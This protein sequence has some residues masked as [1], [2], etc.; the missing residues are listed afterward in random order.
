MV[1]WDDDLKHNSNNSMETL[2]RMGEHIGQRTTNEQR[3]E[4]I[5]NTSKN[6][7]KN[8]TITQLLHHFPRTDSLN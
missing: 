1:K 6:K 5:S 8:T 7:T 4:Y 2:V 3:Q